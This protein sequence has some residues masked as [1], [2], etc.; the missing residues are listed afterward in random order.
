MQQIEQKVS[1]ADNVDEIATKLSRE[2]TSAR[3]DMKRLE[4]RGSKSVED[5]TSARTDTVALSKL[6]YEFVLSYLNRREEPPMNNKQF[7]LAWGQGF[8]PLQRD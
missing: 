2:I 8:M 4:T 6:M 3:A 1:S 7:K 5:A